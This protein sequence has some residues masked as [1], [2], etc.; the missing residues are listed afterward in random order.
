MLANM[1]HQQFIASVAPKVSGSI[2]VA[3]NLKTANLDF[4]V[5]LSSSA[6]VIGNR[7]Q[8]NYSAANAFLD[9]FAKQLASRGIPATSISLGSVLS[10]GWVAE[11][12][13][14]C[15]LLC[16]MGPSQKIVYCPS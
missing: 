4:F 12:K 3:D 9:A 7:G 2:N 11:T 15:P 16:L 14:D 10:V 6:A 5:L 1:S 8:A 13:T